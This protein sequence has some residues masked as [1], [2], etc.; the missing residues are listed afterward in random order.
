MD[1]HHWQSKSIKISVRQLKKKERGR[2]TSDGKITT[3]SK[4][5][6]NHHVVAAE[7]ESEET[8]NSNAKTINGIS[9]SEANKVNGL[10]AMP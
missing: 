8:P 3:R 4:G 9:N 10:A 7:S 1:H 6:E 5:N 2:P